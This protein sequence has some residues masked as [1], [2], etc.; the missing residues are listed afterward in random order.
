MVIL[1]LHLDD[2]TTLDLYVIHLLYKVLTVVCLLA[3]EE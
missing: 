2:G 1:V 3:S